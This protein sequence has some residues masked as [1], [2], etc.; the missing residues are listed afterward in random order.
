M[1]A[2]AAWRLE[3]LGFDDV[4]DYVAGK[5]DWFAAGL[6]RE[7]ANADVIHAGDLLHADVATCAADDALGAVRIRLAEGDV[8]VVVNEH[9]IVLG[10][11]TEKELSTGDERLAGDAMRNGPST[12]RPSVSAK[13][14]A[15]TLGQRKAS[16]TLITTSEGRLLGLVVTDELRAAAEGET[17]T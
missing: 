12:Y 8:C 15:E 6:S 3:S 7:G 4:H 2:R 5:I 16:R 9:G 14:L 10:L 1:S 17:Q 11:L 13:E